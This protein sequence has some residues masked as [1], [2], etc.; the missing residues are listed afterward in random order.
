VP[1]GRGDEQ[2]RAELEEMLDEETT[3]L[4]DDVL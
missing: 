2:I 4:M 3:G 1:F